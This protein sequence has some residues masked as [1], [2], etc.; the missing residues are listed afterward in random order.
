METPGPQVSLPPIRRGMGTELWKSELTMCVWDGL[1]QYTY[2]SCVAIMCQ[3][4]SLNEMVA[5]HMMFYL[6]IKSVTSLTL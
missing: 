4:S 3:A 6:L 2:A 5:L 1:F